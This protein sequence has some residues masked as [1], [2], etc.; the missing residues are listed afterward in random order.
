MSTNL[1]KLSFLLNLNESQQIQQNQCLI[2][3]GNN[4]KIKLLYNSKTFT[5]LSKVA[6]RY[7]QVVR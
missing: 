7:R 6:Q 4:I 5:L 2:I 1:T 3:V